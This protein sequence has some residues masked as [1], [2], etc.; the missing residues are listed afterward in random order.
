MFIDDHVIEADSY[1][2]LQ[3]FIHKLE[4]ANAIY[5]LKIST[6]KMKTMTCK[7]R[8]TVRNKIV[9]NNNTI[10]KMNTFYYLGCSISYQSDGDITVKIS[11]F[12]QVMGIINRTLNPSQVR[13]HTRLQMYNTL[14]LPTILYRCETWAVREDDKLRISAE[15]KF[16]IINAKYTWQDNKTNENILTKLKIN[17]VAKKIQ[18]YRNKRLQRAQ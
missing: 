10:E 1:D 18:N 4:T 11:K 12:L 7:G 8:D 2:A 16:I 15:I 3:I 5:G 14:A 17:P 13:K 6:S 9:T